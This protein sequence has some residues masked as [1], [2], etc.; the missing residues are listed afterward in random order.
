MRRVSSRGAALKRGSRQ[1]NRPSPFPHRTHR[2][3]SRKLADTNHAATIRADSSNAANACNGATRGSI[4]I[5]A[6]IA[7][8]SNRNN[9]PSQRL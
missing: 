5:G 6:W 9:R 3:V 8:I 2:A 4:R 7:P 1:F